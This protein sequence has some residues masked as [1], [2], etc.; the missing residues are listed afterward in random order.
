[1]STPI[2]DIDEADWQKY[3]NDC[4]A[5]GVAPDISDYLVWC[6]ENNIER[7]EIWDGQEQTDAY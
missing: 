4:E 5:A 3:I 6:N 7:P 1:M 2:Y